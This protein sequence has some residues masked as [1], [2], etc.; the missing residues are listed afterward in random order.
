MKTTA[1]VA[2]LHCLTPNRIHIGTAFYNAEAYYICHSCQK[3]NSVTI[4]QQPIE[5]KDIGNFQLG[6]EIK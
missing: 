2:C 6:K 3:A 1:D 4:T 5:Q